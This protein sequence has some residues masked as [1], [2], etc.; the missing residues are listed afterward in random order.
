MNP[1]DLVSISNSSP[2]GLPGCVHIYAPAGQAGEYAALA[3]NPYRGCGHC[4]T[5][6]YVP[7]VIRQSRQEFDAGAVPRPGFI[8]HLRR[9]ARKYQ[10]AGIREQV[11]LSFT[12]DPFHP[13]DTSLTRQTIEVLLD[14]GLGFCTLTKGGGRALACTDLFRP[15]RDAFAS[16]LTSLD[17]A[18]SRKWEP[19]AALPG[20]RIATLKHFHDRGIFTWVSLEPVLDVEASLAIVEA[21]HGFVDLFKIGRINYSALTRTID[22]RSYTERMI[23]LCS[24][25][26]VQHYVKRD[27]ACY[28][29]AGYSNPVRVQ[30]HH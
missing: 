20:D 18:F 5:Y 15:A 9:D 23:E 8:D 16:T 13:G 14:H 4:C 28:L 26:G 19:H 11:L 12:T 29:P 2:A 7:G 1:N 17:E 30:Q 24:R 25:L 22:W 10:A 3:T 6:C 27:L 21:T